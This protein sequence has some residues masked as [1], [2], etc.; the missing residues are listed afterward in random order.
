MMSQKNTGN[1]R[2]TAVAQHTST[3]AETSFTTVTATLPGGAI[4]RPIVIYASGSVSGIVQFQFGAN[5]TY[6]LSIAPNQ[7]PV[8]YVIPKS[9][10]PNR[11]GQVPIQFECSGGV[12][13][14]IAIVEFETD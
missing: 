13:T 4:G 6:A 7:L 5:A 9:A 12:G 3:A 11:T 14:L 2:Q 1:N 8:K 10:F